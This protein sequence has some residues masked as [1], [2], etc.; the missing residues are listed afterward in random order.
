MP[1]PST[2]RR[3]TPAVGRALANVVAVGAVLAALAFVALA[4]VARPVPRSGAEGGAAGGATSGDGRAGLAQMASSG[5]PD[6]VGVAEPRSPAG[7][8]HLVASPTTGT[9][10]AVALVV[11]VASLLLGGPGPHRSRWRRWRARLEGAPPLVA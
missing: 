5:H 6:F 1:H 2:I 8:V 3:R 4:F 10:L 7:L 11:V 9:P